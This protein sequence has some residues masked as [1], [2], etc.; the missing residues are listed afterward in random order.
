MKTKK[1]QTSLSIEEDLHKLIKEEADKN[2]RSFSNQLN[3]IL[4][5]YFKK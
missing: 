4:R 2:I 3:I 1:I 5:E